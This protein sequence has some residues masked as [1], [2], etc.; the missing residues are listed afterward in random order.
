MSA[1]A[2]TGYGSSGTSRAFGITRAHNGQVNVNSSGGISFEQEPVAVPDGTGTLTVGTATVSIDAT[3]DGWRHANTVSA[4][5][6]ATVSYTSP[7][8]VVLLKDTDGS[9]NPATCGDATID[10]STILGMASIIEDAGDT[11]ITW[12]LQDLVDT[13]TAYNALDTVYVCPMYFNETVVASAT[14]VT[15][16]AAAS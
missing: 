14:P 7:G 2:F 3:T 6:T 16:L 8:K 12:A 13:T 1:T 11:S 10:A 5:N 9:G 4:L 15:V